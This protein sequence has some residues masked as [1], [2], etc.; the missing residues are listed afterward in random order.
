MWGSE[1]FYPCK[2]HWQSYSFKNLLFGTICSVP[3][4]TGFSFIL[5]LSLPSLTACYVSFVLVVSFHLCCHCLWLRTTSGHFMV[6]IQFFFHQMIFLNCQSGYFLFLLRK[7]HVG[8]LTPMKGHL[9]RA[10]ILGLSKNS[11]TLIHSLLTISL[12]FCISAKENCVQFSDHSIFFHILLLWLGHFICL[13]CQSLIF[14]FS[15]Y[16][17][18]YWAQRDPRL[19]RPNHRINSSPIPPPCSL[20]DSCPPGR[21]LV[22]ELLGF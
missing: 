8:F 19:R 22:C 6:W 17:F 10:R 5:D 20:S 3:T 12:T 2:W 15:S 16:C 14:F 13:E 9:K 4:I 11:P 7:Q 1:L 18:R 21:H